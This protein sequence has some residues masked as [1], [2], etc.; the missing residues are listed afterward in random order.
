MSKLY[1][2]L[3]LIVV[4]LLML[5]SCEKDEKASANV[6]LSTQEEVDLFNHSQV[7]GDLT[8][9][10]EFIRDLTPLS[11]IERI[12]GFLIVRDYDMLKSLTGLESLRTIDSTLYISDNFALSDLA[13]L[14]GL[15]YV[16]NFICIDSNQKLSSLSGLKSLKYFDGELSIFS[17][18][19]LT[20]MEGFNIISPFD[21]NIKHINKLQH[22]TRQEISLTIT[23]RK[24]RYALRNG[25][26][27]RSPAIPE[28]RNISKKGG[29]NLSLTWELHL[30]KY[31]D[32][33]SKKKFTFRINS[34]PIFFCL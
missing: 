28:S 15:E 29:S 27:K 20:N 18:H 19:L 33:A 10:G 26:F 23:R 17:K 4:L 30:P 6:F 24:V 25:I 9:S 14:S 12:H 21:L 5:S 22:V 16:S 2:E 3:L 32:N 8:I 1:P 34:F 7:Y 11:N 31:Y 13:G